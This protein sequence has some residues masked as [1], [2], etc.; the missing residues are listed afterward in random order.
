MRWTGDL[1]KPAICDSSTSLLGTE[2]PPAETEMPVLEAMVRSRIVATADDLEQLGSA[3][4]ESIQAA[5]IDGTGVSAER[6]FLVRDSR[7]ETSGNSV[8]LKLGLK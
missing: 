2:A 6:V 7:A 4:A 5:L 1:S 3:R 8:R